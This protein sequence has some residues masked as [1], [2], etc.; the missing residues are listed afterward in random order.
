MEI[1]LK[2][3]TNIDING[4]ELHV[5]DETKAYHPTDNVL[6]W[7]MPTALSIPPYS[8]IYNYRKF[9]ALVGIVEKINNTGPSTLLANPENISNID[10]DITYGNDH[11]STFTFALNQDGIYKHYL[12]AVPASNDDIVTLTGI[13]LALSAYYYS[14]VRKEICKSQGAGDYIPVA[15]YEELI[16]AESGNAIDQAKEVILWTPQLD[17][18]ESKLYRQY[19]TD[20]SNCND[21]CASLKKACEL[22]LNV[23]YAQ[24][25]F[26]I[27]LLYDAENIIAN[28]L[29]LINL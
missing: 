7:G 21:Q 15:S 13:D 23:T 6:G 18:L 10:F 29:E 4:F 14:T 22:Q 27:G 24:K 11:Q 28:Q 1:D 20:R 5:T 25:M 2:L 8:L 26:D 3:N 9:Y 12:V 16:D 19:M 17:I